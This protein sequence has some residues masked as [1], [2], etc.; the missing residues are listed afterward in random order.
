MKGTHKIITDYVILIVSFVI[1]W[2]QVWYLEVKIFA[3]ERT[4]YIRFNDAEQR[5][6]TSIT[7]PQ[8][9][10]NFERGYGSLNRRAISEIGSFYS[11]LDSPNDSDNEENKNLLR[12]SQLQNPPLAPLLPDFSNLSLSSQAKEYELLSRE[13]VNKVLDIFYKKEGWK[14][15]KEI[16]ISQELVS[17]NDAADE[18]L[19]IGKVFK[20]ESY[21]KFNDQVILKVLRDDVDKYPLWNKAVKDTKVSIKKI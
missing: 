21:I 3:P 15:D 17:I 7:T 13:V 12:P 6:S 2:I 18:R 19:K 5:A 16:K 9:A 11:P 20:L 14:L 4:D 10:N 1:C 8:A